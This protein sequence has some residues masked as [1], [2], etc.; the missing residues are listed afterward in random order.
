MSGPP[1]WLR[2]RGRYFPTDPER[3]GPSL[4]RLAKR[5]G[6]TG[7]HGLHGL[8]ARWEEVVGQPAASHAQPLALK[9][10]RLRV[11]VDH[12]AWATSLRH[13]ERTL[14][15]RL[16]EVAGPGVVTSI[17]LVVRPR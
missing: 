11:G 15:D 9:D 10:G 6:G 12:A 17:E 2:R 7:S 16:D 3:L 1:P 13:L 4:D 8:F 5:L 14:L